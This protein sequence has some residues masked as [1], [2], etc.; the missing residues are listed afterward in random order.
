MKVASLEVS[1]KLVA[2]D[3]ALVGETH[4]IHARQVSWDGYTK[5]EYAVMPRDSATVGIWESFPAPTAC[6]LGELLPEICQ[7]WTSTTYE[8]VEKVIR[9]VVHFTYRDPANN[10]RTLNHRESADTE[11]DSRGLML[12]WLKENGHLEDGEWTLKR[13]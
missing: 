7:Y 4:F 10:L 11:A 5:E 12:V 9:W 1:K 13:L 8:P 6:E 3:S 2:L